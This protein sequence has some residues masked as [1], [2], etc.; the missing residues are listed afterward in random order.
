MS[1]F[2]DILENSYEAYARNIRLISFFS[3][4]FLLAFLL[5]IV[6]KLPIYVAN[7]G[8]FLRFGSIERGDLSITDTLSITVVFL[9]ALFLFSVALAAINLLMKSQRTLVRLT[10]EN[11]V[12]VE[13]NTFKLFTVFLLAFFITLVANV[14]LYRYFLNNT[15]GAFIALLVSLAVV[16]VPQAVV[17]D[18]LGIIKSV[19][20]SFSVV[21]R[22]ATYFV[23]F[24]LIA[25][26]LLV[27][28]ALIFLWLSGFLPAL[29]YLPLVINALVILPFL[30]VLKTQIYLSKYTLLHKM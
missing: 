17:I 8:I 10:T 21:S 9:V 13:G 20:M 24:L 5:V 11:I 1:G 15:V 25:A 16:F 28:N 3:V 6:F 4:P 26:A 19:K 18:G 12:Q 2:G 7:G 30:E 29:I 27:L 14:Y 22:R 23:F